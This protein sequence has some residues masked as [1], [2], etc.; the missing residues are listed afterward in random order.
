[1]FDGNFARAGVIADK[2]ARRFVLQTTDLPAEKVVP[3]LWTPA[4]ETS[5]PGTEIAQKFEHE[6]RRPPNPPVAGI[7]RRTIH[8]GQQGH[9]LALRFEQPRYLVG[10][11]AAETIAA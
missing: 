5:G 10:D 7:G 2:E 1:L 8:Q 3:L 11:V 4:R 6:N 9:P